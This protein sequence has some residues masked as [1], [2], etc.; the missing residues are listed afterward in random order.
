MA[1]KF[2]VVV[3]GAGP[4][5]YV[6]AIRCAQLGMRTACV[7]RWLGAGNQPSLGGTCLNVGCIPSK[8]LLEASELFIEAARGAAYGIRTQGVALDLPGMM[9]HKD[10][11]V[12]ELTGGVAQLFR[13]HGIAWVA[14]KGKLLPNHR[15]EATEHNG[16]VRT[17]EGSN[18]IL[19]SGSQP[20][21]LGVAPLAGD[22]VVDSTGALSFDSVP[23]RLGIIGAGVIGLE[24]GSVWQRLGS[25]VVLLEAQ[26]RFLAIADGQVAR[27]AYKQFSAQGLDIRLGARVLGSKV[28][29]KG[30]T[31]EYEDKSGAQRLECDRLVV[32]VGRRPNTEGLYD[33]ETELLLDE[34]GFVHVDER[35]RTNLP[36]VYAVGD[37]VRGPMLAHKGMEEGVM[38]AETIAGHHAEV[39]YD[40][41]PSVIYTSPEIAW[42]GKTEE[43][44]KAAGVDYRAGNFPFAANG[45]AKAL[46][47]TGG[48][49]KI[50]S[51]ARTDRVLGVHMIG[52]Q[53]AELIALGV[54]AMEFG[55]SSEDIA[56]T[57]FA[58]PS[59]S[60]SFHEAALSVLG[61]PLHVAKAARTPRAAAGGADG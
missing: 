48:F 53:C 51:D 13:A 46:G 29:E 30:V 44:L 2:D 20:V 37:V 58:H 39:N 47:Q 21:E 28:T 45:R 8:A 27:E 22:R 24:L 57:M 14:G 38:V 36:G 16:S 12:G 4:A 7:D 42:A 9:R 61:R 49:I 54:M 31:V 23:A 59:L 10:K 52:P 56:L 43:A 3:I 60:E 18:V 15:V 11:V 41:I 1:D 6:A 32:A 17:L 5:G 35:C 26:E 55:A 50:L 33:A 19:A 40:I 34:F 25:K